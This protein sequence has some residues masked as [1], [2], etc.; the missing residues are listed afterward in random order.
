MGWRHFQHQ[1]PSIHGRDLTMD[2]RH[3]L[4]TASN[5][6][7]ERTTRLWELWYQQKLF[8]DTVD[9]KLG[10]QS[11]DQEFMV[12][13]F[14]ALFI[15]AMMGWP[16]LPSLDLDAGGPAYPL[17]SL[18]IRFRVHPTD[19]LT[20]LA[21]VFDDNPPGGPANND[22]Q[23]RGAEAA[24]ARFNLGTGALF[25]TELQYA[26]NQPSQDPHAPP[27]TGLPGVYKLGAWF[28]IGSFPDQE[29]DNTGLSLA[30]PLSAGIPQMHRGNFSICAVAD[31]TVWQPDPK[32][33][34]ELGVFVRAVGA[35]PDMNVVTFSADTGLNLKAL[36]PGRDS[37]RFGI[38]YGVA[39]ISSRA[40]QL[41]LDTALFTGVSHPVRSAEHFVEVTYQF[42]AAGWWQIQPDF[43]C[44]IN[45]GG[46]I[47][48]P[49]VPGQRIKDEAV[50]GI[51]TTI[52]F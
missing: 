39:K 7:A 9:V 44:V 19:A 14:S 45:P 33:P 37:D 31:Q 18:G 11:A 27:P 8:N 47:P 21:G 52:T 51:R 28:D 15:N 29:L 34:Q 12:S 30:N 13:Q 50:L 43:Q 5:I 22:S 20:V 2:N 41:D 42:Q 3:I 48:N 36:P 16:A 1:R 17:S 23:L 10:Q 6:D 40:V 25:L 38:G 46:G 35:P 49:N 4:Q 32:S 24:G 26:I